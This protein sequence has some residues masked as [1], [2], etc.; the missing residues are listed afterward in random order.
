MSSR[1]IEGLIPETHNWGKSVA[2]W[3]DLGPLP[4][5]VE[6]PE[7][8]GSP[9]PSRPAGVRAGMIEG[10]SLASTQP[11]YRPNPS[12]RG[13]PPRRPQDQKKAK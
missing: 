2:F 6:A 11:T 8:H 4:D 12:G 9:I 1:G 10:V 7:G 13:V 5:D 3:R